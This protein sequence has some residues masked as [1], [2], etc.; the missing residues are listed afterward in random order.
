MDDR[1]YSI[2]E[3]LD[4]E[5]ETLKNNAETMGVKQATTKIHKRVKEAMEIIKEQTDRAHTN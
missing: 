2:F 3:E 5:V 4:T 1:L